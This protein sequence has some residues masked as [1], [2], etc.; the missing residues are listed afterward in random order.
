MTTALITGGTSGIGAAFARALA[1]RGDDLV[2]VARDP[3]RLATTA[4]AL[5][6]EYGVSVETLTADLAERDQALRVADR[7]E[8]ADRP[9][10]MLVSNAGFGVR[11]KLLDTDTTQHEQSF[12]VMVRAVLILGGAAGRAMKARGNGTIINVSST[13]GYVT[14]GSYSATKSWVTVYTESLANELRGTGVRVTVLCPG[15]VRTEFHERAD[16]SSSR[17]PSYLWLDADRLVADCL[18]DVRRSRVISIPSLRYKAL[19][20]AARHVPRS[21]VRWLS[22]KLASSRH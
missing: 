6:D 5:H 8:S 9:I 11:A 19:M 2:L 15:W 22:G 12:D 4:A 20:L 1:A 18:D 21:G 10:D 13:A 14:M 7:L 3:E 16:I 17:I